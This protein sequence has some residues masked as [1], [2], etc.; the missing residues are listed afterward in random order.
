MDEGT[1]DTVPEECGDKDGAEMEEEKERSSSGDRSF[2]VRRKFGEGWRGISAGRDKNTIS[3]RREVGI[4]S[5]NLIHENQRGGYTV[6][7]IGI[8]GG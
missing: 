2:R 8:G 1:C 5:K 3:E 4:G 7:I 6:V